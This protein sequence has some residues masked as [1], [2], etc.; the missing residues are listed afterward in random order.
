V[1]T[2]TSS[3]VGA[4]HHHGNLRSALIETATELASTKGPD[5]V[6]LREVARL[7]GVSHN[8]A[9]R[10]FA[11]R[12]GLLA[13]VAAIGQQRL[14]EA[15]RKRLAAVRATDPAARATARHGETGRAHVQFALDQPGLFRVAF[16]TAPAESEEA[17]AYAV[18]L[19]ALDDLIALGLLAAGSRDAAAVT[20]R[21]AVHG[22]T[23]RASAVIADTA[24]R[25]VSP[26]SR[27]SDR[28]VQNDT[29]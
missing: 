24:E 16:S 22:A 5:G 9:Y 25:F 23:A 4:P 29:A 14:A 20:C 21:S 26:L 12:E 1:L 3:A 17:D 7:A 18:L 8:A 13:E 11:D 2:P 27:Q 15:M 10:H 6:V 19:A 28:H